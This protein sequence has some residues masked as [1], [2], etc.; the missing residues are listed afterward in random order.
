MKLSS[1]S[2][3]ALGIRRQTL[4]LALAVAAPLLFSPLLLAD[5]GDVSAPMPTP[6]PAPTAAVAGL[7]LED[8][9]R[10]VLKNNL[11]VRMAKT[12]FESA[13]GEK[14]QLESRA[15]P[16]IGLGMAAGQQ[17]WRQNQPY[18]RDFIIV[19]GRLGQRLFDAA[20]PASFRLGKL[21]LAIAEQRFNGTLLLELS[22]MRQAFYQAI[23]SREESAIRRSIKERVAANLRATENQF[24]VG[25]VS[26][27]EVNQARGRLSALEPALVSAEA[28]YRQN[29]IKLAQFLGCDIGADNAAT[30]DAGLPI[31][32]GTLEPQPLTVDFPTEIAYTLAHRSDILAL[33]LAI[34]ATQEQRSMTRAG[35]WPTINLEASNTYIPSNPLEKTGDI[36]QQ[37]GDNKESS[38]LNFGPSLSWTIWDE[39]R[40]RG[41]TIQID[42]AREIYEMTL[43]R[44]EDD[45]PR[46]L[47]QV[48]SGLETVAAQLEGSDQLVALAD[49]NL[50]QV[51]AQ[52]ANGELP[53]LDFLNAE[54]NLLQA[55]LNRLRA[56]LNNNIAVTQFD[57]IT[58]R[59]LEFIS[60]LPAD[61]SAAP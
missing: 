27:R 54:R 10:E 33:R 32:L 50:Q 35:Y 3:M 48:A 51:E 28:D 25:K 6:A 2:R 61:T 9:Y 17:G 13:T 19:Q 20:I 38:T 58:G 49:R 44:I 45:V 39:G 23:K 8:C 53:Q 36:N 21:D 4:G 46:N 30:L 56:L 24:T 15:L 22:G 7:T 60:Q 16:R 52:I 41:Q 11:N 47:K 59:Y 31:P 37:R 34:T 57:L 29:R 12:Q 55:R 40:I 1:L 43:K 5:P 18:A 26:R 42:A 14:I